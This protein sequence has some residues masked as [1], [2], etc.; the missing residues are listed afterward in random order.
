MTILRHERSGDSPTG[1]K[2]QSLLPECPICGESTRGHS[3]GQLASTRISENKRSVV[4]RFFGIVRQHEWNRL[5][6]FKDWGSTSDNL[7][8]YAIR[9]EHP[10]GVLIVLKDVFEV[11]GHDEIVLQETVS[12]PE[13]EILSATA[14]LEWHQ[15]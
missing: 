13:M 10:N 15:M 11:Y 14:A 5:M 2:L 7:V 4:T 9:G 1:A 8:A 6:E 3:F 12:A